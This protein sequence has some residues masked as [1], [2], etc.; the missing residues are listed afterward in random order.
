MC[1]SGNSWTQ[2][3]GLPNVMGNS[4]M[5]RSERAADQ[6]VFTATTQF[7]GFLRETLRSLPSPA[8]VTTTTAPTTTAPTTSHASDAR[9]S[10]S[11]LLLLSSIY[12]FSAL[13]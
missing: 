3:A 9:F 13:V 10:M 8:N 5:V 7:A 6:S 11:Y 4:S 12:L 1:K 2:V